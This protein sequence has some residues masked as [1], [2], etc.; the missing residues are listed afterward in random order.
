MKLLFLAFA[1]IF[2][3]SEAYGFFGNFGEGPK[4]GR[5]G[6]GG[7]MP[8][9]PFGHRCRP[10]AMLPK[11]EE[12]MKKVHDKLKENGSGPFSCRD[13]ENR[14][15][16]KF[17]ELMKARLAIPEKPSSECLEQVYEFLEGV[18]E[19]TT[20]STEEESSYE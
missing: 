5:G 13:A 12:F 14:N 10:P 1:V 4:G 19:T 15:E 3:A 11:C 17:N 20:T 2:L 16:C 8:P 9:P 6:P 7:M 18:S